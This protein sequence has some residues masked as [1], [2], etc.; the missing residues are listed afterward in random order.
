MRYFV[1]YT[2]DGKIFNFDKKCSYI[3]VLDGTNDILCFNETDM[4]GV[5]KRTL[6]LIPKDMILYVLLRRIDYDHS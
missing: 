4:L 1:V 2:K 5:G 6:A 3:D